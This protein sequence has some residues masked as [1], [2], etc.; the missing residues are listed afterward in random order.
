[1]IESVVFRTSTSSSL[2]LCGTRVLQD[3]I[4]DVVFE[5]GNGR[6]SPGTLFVVVNGEGDVSSSSFALGK[7]GFES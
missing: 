5:F 6:A 1:M 7:S 4:R 3:G 2:R